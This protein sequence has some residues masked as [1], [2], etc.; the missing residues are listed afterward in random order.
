[1]N[2]S[3]FNKDQALGMVSHLAALIALNRHF[4]RSVRELAEWMTNVIADQGYYA[5]QGR[6]GEYRLEDFVR[7]FVRGR[8]LVYDQIEVEVRPQM[9]TIRTHLWCLEDLPEAFYYYSVTPEEYSEFACSLAELHA[10]RC[11]FNITLR[12][13]GALETAHVQKGTSIQC[14]EA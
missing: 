13:S 14:E 11:G 6:L 3:Q 4:G 5:E 7:D 1:M 10:N 9:A 12:H 2:S 8:G